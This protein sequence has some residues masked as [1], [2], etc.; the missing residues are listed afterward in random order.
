MTRSAA[1][2]TA[3]LCAVLVT[4]CGGPPRPALVE[5]RAPK[6]PPSPTADGTVAG[7]VFDETTGVGLVG[8]S[9]VVSAV[10][11]PEAAVTLTDENG[12]YQLAVSPGVRLLSLYYMDYQRSVAVTIVA[13]HKFELS[14]SVP[15][16]Q[17][18]HP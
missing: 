18:Q 17:N 4:A 2:P 10:D 13:N 5:N 11:L 12:R 16:G 7:R 9:I 1:P 8:A 14:L 6:N 3:L 15:V